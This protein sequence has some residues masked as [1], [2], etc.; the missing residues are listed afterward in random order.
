MIKVKM[1]WEFL[2]H[3]SQIL[4]LTFKLIHWSKKNRSTW[5]G[6]LGNSVL[7][8]FCLLFLCVWA[9]FYKMCIKY[10]NLN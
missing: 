9:N 8:L 5:N 6:I 7:N 2:I 3:W 10:T 4:R 1:H